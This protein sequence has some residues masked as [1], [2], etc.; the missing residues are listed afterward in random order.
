MGAACPVAIVSAFGVFAAA[1]CGK[2]RK[3]DSGTAAAGEGVFAAAGS[4]IAGAVIGAADV[5][6][7]I[8]GAVGVFTGGTSGTDAVCGAMSVIVCATNVGCGKGASAAIVGIVGVVVG[9]VI[10]DA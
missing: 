1:G 6:S 5:A 9:G 3:V 7:G 2:V 8:G 10:A 4:G